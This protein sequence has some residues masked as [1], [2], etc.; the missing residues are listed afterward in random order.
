MHNGF[1]VDDGTHECTPV[2]LRRRGNGDVWCRYTMRVM[3]EAPTDVQV[4][5]RNRDRKEDSAQRLDSFAVTVKSVLTRLVNSASRRK[6]ETGR[7]TKARTAALKVARH[8]WAE[9][10]ASG[11]PIILPDIMHAAWEHM[12]RTGGDTPVSIKVR[13]LGPGCTRGPSPLNP[14][15][16]RSVD[17]LLHSLGSFFRGFGG[18]VPQSE[19]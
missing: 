4:C 3:H 11:R 8:R 6:T 18:L 17:R 19:C 12:E 13:P 15:S 7:A 14:L 2:C 9:A 5:R 1:I 16:T 10:L